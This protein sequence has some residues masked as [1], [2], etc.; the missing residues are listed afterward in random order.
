VRILFLTY[1]YLPNLGGVERSV[2]NLARDLIARGHDVVVATHDAWALPWRRRPHDVPPTLRLHVPNQTSAS[3]AVAAF[4]AAMNRLNLAVLL[5]F[6]RR[7]RVEVVHA[8]HLSL[9]TVYAGRLADRLGLRMVLTLRGG[10]IEEWMHAPGRRAYVVAQLARADRVTA[11]S[12]AL[13]AQAAALVP[14]IAACGSVVPNPADPARILAAMGPPGPAPA[15]PY[16]AFAGRLE[17]MK[18]VACLVDAYH[19]LAAR[20]PGFP[21]DLIVAG[22][23]RLAPALRERARAGAGAG[24]IRFAGALPYPDTLRLVAG[25]RALV[26]PSRASEGCPNVVLEAMALGTPVVV[27]D[28]PSLAELVTDGVDGAVFPVGDAT[29]LADRLRAVVGDDALRARLA[30]AARARLAAR[31]APAATVDRYLALYATPPRTAR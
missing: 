8:H 10:E 15:R 11:V 5:R 23:G 6:C 19:A 4:R 25:A 24:R 22:D 28:L 3:P 27:S 16:L 9:D 7:R 29:A 14:A 2:H 31:H 20:D 30:G 17:P 1:S 12:A 26:L 13:L 21:A 18:D